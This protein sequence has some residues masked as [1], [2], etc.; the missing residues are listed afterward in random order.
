MGIYTKSKTVLRESKQT[1]H[2]KFLHNVF[3]NKARQN[4]NKKL[5]NNNTA[6]YSS[7]FLFSKGGYGYYFIEVNKDS[8]KTFKIELNTKEFSDKMLVLKR[9]HK[10]E[11]VVHEVKPGES[12]IILYRLKVANY[13]ASVQTPNPKITMV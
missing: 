11:T 5:L 2:P 10:A 7:E 4:P 13:P 3:E 1:S 6:T 8:P 9:P 12:L